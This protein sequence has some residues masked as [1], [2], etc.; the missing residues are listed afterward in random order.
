MSRKDV[1]EL[2]LPFYKALGFSIPKNMSKFLL[3]FVLFFLTQPQ[4]PN[5][6]S[7]PRVQFNEVY[8]W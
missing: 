5:K 6:A 3:S 1:G 7:L 4:I 8:S 2:Q